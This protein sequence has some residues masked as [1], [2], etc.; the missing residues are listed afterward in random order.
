MRIS[1]ISV[2][3]IKQKFVKEGERE[4]LERLQ[5]EHKIEL[6]ELGV[7]H[8]AS[9]P[10]VEI[11]SKEAKQ[12]LASVKD[13]QVVITLD[14]NGETMTSQEFAAFLGAKMNQG[15]PNIAFIIGGAYGLDPSVKKR[16]E[17]S[18]SLSRMT[19]TYQ[20]SRLILVEQLYRA[21]MILKGSPYHK[22]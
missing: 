8:P 7:D 13:N 22:Q 3:K 20:M 2:G 16:A 9:L 18:I 5:S 11:K 12:L 19:F 4:Y 6:I 14:E 15:Q 17:K 21:S 1:V 10:E